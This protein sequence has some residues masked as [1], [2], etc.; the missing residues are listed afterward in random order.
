MQPGTPALPPTG[1]RTL[2]AAAELLLVFHKPALK[3]VKPHIVPASRQM[4]HV[5]P[6]LAPGREVTHRLCVK[7]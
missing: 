2:S 3:F 7:P 1:G 5:L 4:G 6:Q